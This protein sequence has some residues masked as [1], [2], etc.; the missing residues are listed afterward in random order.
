[1][2]FQYK[3]FPELRLKHGVEKTI[4]DPVSIT[5]NGNRE[6]RRKINK[7][8]RYSWNIPS[9]NLMQ[10]EIEAIVKFADEVG[11]DSFLYKD[12]TLPELIDQ[13]LTPMDTGPGTGYWFGLYHSG[14]HPVLN[15][16]SY[17]T[18]VFESWEVGSMLSPDIV[19]KINGVPIDFSI[20]T[21]GTKMNFTPSLFGSTLPRTFVVNKSFQPYFN[22]SEVVTYSGPLY[23]AV[24]F[25]SMI[26]YRISAMKKS[27]LLDGPCDV[28]PVVS[29]LADIKLMEVFEYDL[30]LE[31]Y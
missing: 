10:D 12:P 2:S 17:G 13:P 23:H 20:G 9:R 5:S 26:S 8:A 3:I 31:N 29:E 16:G 7:T 24:R 25:D 21:Y 6:I 11:T 18:G 28:V 14:L 4:N 22:G 30:G 19:I 27:T 15:L 1:M